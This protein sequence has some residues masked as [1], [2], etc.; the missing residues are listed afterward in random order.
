[1]REAFYPGVCAVSLTVL[2]AC[3]TEQ[4]QAASPASDLHHGVLHVLNW[5]DYI[6]ESSIP[7]F[8]A[9]TGIK[10]V[11]DVY[12]SN[13]MLS[14]KL[15]TGNSGYDVVFPSGEYLARDIPAGV[16]LP[17]DKSRLPNL[18][19]LDPAITRIAGTYD[20]GNQY[21]I[22]YLW[23]TTGI[24]YNPE[25]VARLLGTRKIDSWSV[26]FDPETASKLA[27]CGIA[28]LDS[29]V[30]IFGP[31]K[32][33]LGRDIN[34]ETAEDLADA[35]ELLLKVAPLVRYFDSSRYVNDLATGEIC[36]AI[37]WSYGI[38]QAQV[39]G[40]QAAAPVEIDY[41]LPKEGAPMWFDFAAIPVDAPNP[42]GA[43]AFLDFLLEP[44][45]IATISNTVG[46]PSGN[47]TALPLVEASIRDNP[48]LYPTAEVMQRLQAYQPPSQEFT[49]RVNRAWTRIRS[50]Q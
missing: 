47:S 44:D 37:G 50:G 42:E 12:D 34:S 48:N 21:A 23:G 39:R 17:L 29:A 10:V 36:I 27:S 11:Y 1:M 38:Y 43:H 33:Y 49:R 4:E 6:G 13:E 45:V 3:G 46:Q 18:S 22:P 14:T 31:A 9:R 19:H 28:M 2:A 8:E 7:D 30:G 25:K 15:L 41:V 5:A 16:F 40:A 35:E 26:L 32:I 20:P 24:G